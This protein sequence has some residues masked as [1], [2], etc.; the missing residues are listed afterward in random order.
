[1]MLSWLKDLTAFMR[2]C[3]LNPVACKFLF[4]ISKLKDRGILA[5]GPSVTMPCKTP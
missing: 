1:M 5:K 2:P 4:I 3:L